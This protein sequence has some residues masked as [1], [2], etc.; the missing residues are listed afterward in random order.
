MGEKELAASSSELMPGARAV[1]PA[2]ATASAPGNAPRM[3]A[4]S[5]GDDGGA[6]EP[7]ETAI[8]KSKSNIT[9]N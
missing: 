5:P 2:G 4:S 6:P 7:E 1:A 3:S 8:V 9:N